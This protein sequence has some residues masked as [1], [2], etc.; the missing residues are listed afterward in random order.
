[1]KNLHQF[2]KLI[3]VADPGAWPP[4]YFRL[5]LTEDITEGRKAG[6]ASKKNCLDLP[7]NTILWECHRFNYQSIRLLLD[8]ILLLINE[9]LMYVILSEALDK[10][11]KTSEK[12]YCELC[13]LV[14]CY[15]KLDIA[16]SVF[17][18]FSWQVNNFQVS[19]ADLLLGPQEFFYLKDAWNSVR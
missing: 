3:Q 6:R 1:M 7:L 19:Q 8:L 13:F 2:V 15:F 14:S 12:R 16:E 17:M 4:W 10:E 18:A 5:K 9:N 11:K